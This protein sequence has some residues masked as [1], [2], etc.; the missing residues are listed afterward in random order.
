MA[1]APVCAL[2]N[3]DDNHRIEAFAREYSDRKRRGETPT[4][5]EYA[6]RHPEIASRILRLLPG[7]VGEDLTDETCDSSQQWTSDSRT[8]PGFPELSDYRVIRQIGRG[9]MG[10]V[11]EAEQKSLGRRVALKVLPG[12]FASSTERLER[13]QREARAAARMHHTNIVPVFEVG[14][15]GQTAFYVMQL[16]AGQTLD[17]VVRGIKRIRENPQAGVAVEKSAMDSSPRDLVSE[18]IETPF[19]S[20]GAAWPG[21]SDLSNSGSNGHDYFNSV[22][23]IGLQVAEALAYAHARGI[24][25]RDIKPA[26]LLLDTSGVTWVTDFGLAKTAEGENTRTGDILGTLRYMAPERFR[27]QCDTR[28]DVYA[29]GLTL[30]ELL[31]LEPA[32]ASRDHATLL[33][34][35]AKT[36]P[37]TPRSCDRRIP[38]DLET[39]VVKAIEKDPAQRYQSA[40]AIA[41]D[42]RRFLNEEP[43]RARPISIAERFLRWT[44]QNKLIAASAATFM[45]LLV[46]WAYRESRN[47]FDLRTRL[48]QQ[49]LVQGQTIC[50]AGR[51]D[52]GLHFFVRA[53]DECPSSSVALRGT[54]RA[55]FATWSKRCNQ[56]TQVLDHES[57][58][59]VGGVRDTGLQIA[60]SHDGTRLLTGGKRDGI[61]R[62]WSVDSGEQIGK[63]IQLSSPVAMLRVTDDGNRI[64][65]Q[66]ADGVIQRWNRNGA[67]LGELAT[68]DG[69]VAFSPG[70]GL[71]AAQ[72]SDGTISLW[73]VG[74]GQ[75]ERTLQNPDASSLTFSRDEQHLRAIRSGGLKIWNVESGELIHEK[76]GLNGEIAAVHPDGDSIIIFEEDSPRVCSLNG[77]TLF[78][79]GG[80]FRTALFSPTGQ[81]IA[82]IGG[83][84]FQLWTSEGEKITDVMRF[85]G[86]NMMSFAFSENGELMAIGTNE[87][88]FS[89]WSTKSGE[90]IGNSVTRDASIRSIAFR[91]GDNKLA[92][93]AAGRAEVWSYPKN[94][95]V[96]ASYEGHSSGAWGMEF[97]SAGDQFVTTAFGG[98]V[99]LHSRDPSRTALRMPTPSQNMWDGAI[100]PDGNVVA[101]GGNKQV[102]VWTIEG[103]VVATLEHEEMVRCV[104]FDETGKR[105]ASGTFGGLARVWDIETKEVVAT[106]DHANFVE[107]VAFVPGQNTLVTACADGFARIHSLDVPKKETITLKHGDDV[108]GLDIS[109]DGTLIATGSRDQTVRIWDSESGT[110]IGNVLEHSGHVEDVSFSGD[111]RILATACS[112]GLIRVWDVA[113]R[114]EVGPAIRQGKA[115][116]VVTF[117]PQTG[118]ILASIKDRIVLLPPP[119]YGKEIEDFRSRVKAITGLRFDERNALLRMGPSEWQQARQADDL[120]NGRH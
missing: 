107:D 68:T 7:L 42:L 98:E 95:V 22:A 102:S 60:F 114:Q 13:F 43:I 94:N 21:D 6:A 29:I 55:N 110:M 75:L 64:V 38:K 44:R 51:I 91:P 93:S 37:P 1:R 58:R 56:L 87:F 62:I 28:A 71:L 108:L 88:T 18:T 14:H 73:D 3:I 27:G 103:K 26:N 57:D 61:V 5:E 84:Y 97:S 117:D 49:Y 16:I 19:V 112:D 46:G 11:Y 35:I 23:R 39:I 83:G 100:S 104:D 20:S 12:E 36:A 59:S 8:R 63:P 111:G 17:D 116:R 77:E 80:R 79:L 120:A 69:F 41:E 70:K 40:D 47:S 15:E 10:I 34:T 115:V 53:L 89:I 90:R 31:T 2:D 54:I 96:A 86:A 113:S 118:G 24:I 30:Y 74:D 66:S 33:D 92:V 99:W 65:T 52:H 48:A 76:D 4:V 67:P 50:E 45:I 32:F 85:V 72:N 101:A 81:T 119:E 109:P 78:E 105:L 82:F 9:G 25:H 106:F